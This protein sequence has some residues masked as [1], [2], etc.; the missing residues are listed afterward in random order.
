M[1]RETKLSSCP[2]WLELSEDKLSF[3]RNDERA[4]VV[5]MIFELSIAGLGGY[6]IAKQ[7]NEKQVPVFGP[8]PRWDQSTIHNL[9]VNRATYGEHQPKIYPMGKECP[10]GDPIPGYYPAIITTELFE[11]AQLVR[12]NNLTFGR[13]RKGKFI[14][15]LFPNLL[16][17]GHCGSRVKFHSNGNAKS[18]ICSQVIDRAGCYRMAWSVRSFENALFDLIQ[19]LAVDETVEEDERQKFNLFVPHIRALTGPN[20]YD[21]RMSIFI[22]LKRLVS[23]LKVGSVGKNA[24]P[25]KPAARIRRDGP[26]RYLEIKLCGGR[27]HVGLPISNGG[28]TEN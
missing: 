23:E 16:T 27:S 19:R 2:A 24:E 14:T 21:G 20:N 9:L 15:N 26:G 1:K 10:N 5:K 18:L 8:S 6:T 3:V 12:R 22:L 13:G 25:T 7:L 4:N 17:C 11:T 28:H